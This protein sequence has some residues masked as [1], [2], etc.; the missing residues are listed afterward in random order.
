MKKSR[1]KEKQN[2]TKEQIL[3]GLNNAGFSEN[4]A[5]YL[6]KEIQKAKNSVKRAK[7]SDI[8]WL[9]YLI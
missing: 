5:I 6:F 8:D 1:V 9:F 7:Y 3:N 4:E 2:F